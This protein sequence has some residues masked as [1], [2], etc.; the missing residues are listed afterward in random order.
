MERASFVIMNLLVQEAIKQ[1]M[2]ERGGGSR[3]S[4]V[5]IEI[6]REPHGVISNQRPNAQQTN[7]PLY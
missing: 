5:K 4:G 3:R 7:V 6:R 1:E 2:K